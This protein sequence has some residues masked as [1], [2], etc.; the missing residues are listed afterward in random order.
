ACAFSPDGE[1]IV[2]GSKDKTLKLWDARTGAL[3]PGL[4]PDVTT[5]AWRPG[6]AVLAGAGAFLQLV[7][8][9]DGATVFLEAS[10]DGETQ[11][12]LAYTDDGVFDGDPVA[13]ARLGYRIG[14][15]LRTA[16]V[17]TG[18]QLT[19]VFRHTHL[20]ADLLDGRPVAPGPGTDQ[21]ISLPP[22]VELADIPSETTSPEIPVGVRVTDV[23][24]GI[25]GIRVLV[26]GRPIDAP[27]RPEQQASRAGDGAASRSVTASLTP[28]DNEII[29]EADSVL[30]HV[31]SVRARAHVTFRAT[32]PS[33]TVTGSPAVA[34]RPT[35]AEQDDRSGDASGVTWIANGSTLGAA[36]SSGRFMRLWDTRAG[37][38][39]GAIP[40]PWNAAR[41][42]PDGVTLATSDADGTVHLWDLRA[43]ALRSALRGHTAEVT[44]IAWSADGASLAT[45]SGDAT[46]RLWDPGGGTLRTTL[47]GHRGGVATVTWSPDGATL[48]SGGD[49]GTI[50]LWDVRTG[51]RRSTLTCAS[52]NVPSVVWAAGGATALSLCGREA[53]LTRLWDA[54]SGRVRAEFVNEEADCSL[55]AWLSPDGGTIAVTEDCSSSAQLWDART[56]TVRATLRGHTAGI[57]TVGWSPD[58]AT[59]ATGS[60][61]ASIR[62]WDAGTGTLRTTLQGHTSAVRAL[63]WSSDGVTLASAGADRTVRLWNAR[64]GALRSTLSTRDVAEIGWSPDGAILAISNPDVR[65]VRAADGAAI[66]LGAFGARGLDPAVV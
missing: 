41:M 57:W 35:L 20:V 30:G 36:A 43:G 4:A 50:G 56:G 58:G 14:A 9:V 28:G 51:T 13:F 31:H 60:N 40:G 33:P 34:G 29:A 54:H 26:N 62:L 25:A 45:S 65:L 63:A 1:T 23:G 46:V 6:G 16:D 2:S 27:P 32:V 12:G 17:L 3:R 22:A 66:R 5:I 49:D 19:E 7:R 59:L 18:D 64:T 39:R 37:V 21:D 47:S 24:G 48:A 8:T 42:S 15:D 38:V 52:A 53:V 55:G 61:D 10:P 11:A 44:D